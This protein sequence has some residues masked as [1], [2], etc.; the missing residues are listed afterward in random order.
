[1]DLF[2]VRNPD[3]TVPPMPFCPLEWRHT[4]V[5][6][7]ILW[8]V[9]AQHHCAT[10]TFADVKQ[11]QCAGLE[12]SGPKSRK[13]LYFVILMWVIFLYIWCYRIHQKCKDNME[14]IGMW[15]LWMGYSCAVPLNGIFQKDAHWQIVWLIGVVT[16]LSR[17][18]FVRLASSRAAIWFW[19][20]KS[21]YR[22][23][24]IRCGH[25][26]HFW[27]T[28][29]ET[30]FPPVLCVDNVIVHYHKFHHQEYMSSQFLAQHAKNMHNALYHVHSFRLYGESGK[31]DI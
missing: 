9:L 23:D 10:L 5:D 28:A 4:N 2:E 3:S 27:S 17:L 13:V 1:M 31:S 14:I 18:V 21:G 29:S 24:M 12:K 22:G 16:R 7:S 19:A 8:C 30:R 20:L 11:S 26:C 15:C 6:I 25:L